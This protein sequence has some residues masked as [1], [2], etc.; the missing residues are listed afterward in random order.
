MSL[1][2][3]PGAVPS[4]PLFKKKTRP[5]A[6]RRRETS[7]S[8]AGAGPSSA[9]A[10]SSASEVIVPTRKAA[11][12]PLIQ[13]TK[14]R[15]DTGQGDS[16]DAADDNGPDYDQGPDVK[17]KAS[18]RI[19][20][21]IE[22]ERQIL[23]GEEAEQILKKQRRELENEDRAEDGLYHGAASYKQ[24]IK[25]EKEIPKAMR[26]GPQKS[27]GTIRTVTFMDYQPDVCKDYKGACL[28]CFSSSE[29]ILTYVTFRNWVLWFRR[30]LQVPS[31]PWN[32]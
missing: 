23:E 12:N 9:V 17:W 29:C 8:G 14:R 19:E 32:M 15:R 16:A 21:I 3:A 31:R 10:T 4:V 11:A 27:N 18:G 22:R 5:T 26:V 24:H 30:H 1:E 20:D 28:H 6:S 25:K 2:P 13:G 7:P